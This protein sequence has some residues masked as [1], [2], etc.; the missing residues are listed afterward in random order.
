MQ[1]KKQTAKPLDRIV[2]LLKSLGHWF[3]RNYKRILIILLG[4]IV[5]WLILAISIGVWY[6]HKH[7]NDPFVLGVSF[8][9]DYSESL[10]LDWRANYLALLK[11]GFKNFRLMSYWNDVEPLKGQYNFTDLDWQ[12]NE[13]QAYGAK[14][15]L[16]IGRRQPRWPEC[17]DPG[18]AVNLPTSE[19]NQQVLSFLKVVVDRYKNNPALQSYQ[20]ENEVANRLFSP[21][22]PSFN[23]GFLKTEVAAVKAIDSKHPLILNASNQS[24]IPL[25]GP[26]GDEVGFSIYRKVYAKFG[27]IHTYFSYSFVPTLWDSYRAGVLELLFHVSVFTHELQA[28]PWG[29]VGTIDMTSAQQAQSMTAQGIEQNVQYSYGAGIHTMYLWGSEWWYWRMTK[30]HDPS[31]WNMVHS[32]LK[33][34]PYP[35]TILN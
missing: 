12:M 31:E 14:V 9:E 21:F 30:F 32:I 20:L 22:C 26:I 35:K 34:G 7:R 29:P 4:V 13:A 5:A 1:K 15:S 18:W 25:F 8:S 28:E 10:G 17:H 3:K 27:I 6:Q 16:S 24:G 2:T 19:Q 11:M 23:R 33:E